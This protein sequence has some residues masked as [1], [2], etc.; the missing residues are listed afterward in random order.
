MVGRTVILTKSGWGSA[1]RSEE[2]I[3]VHLASNTLIILSHY[4]LNPAFTYLY[5]SFGD[6]T[7]EYS[8]GLFSEVFKE[9]PRPDTAVSLR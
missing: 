5:K 2:K 7:K 4:A 6:A 8:L 3:G 1:Y 9:H